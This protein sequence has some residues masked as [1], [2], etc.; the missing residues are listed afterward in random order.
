MV[1]TVC[2]HRVMV[3]TYWGPTQASTVFNF[4]SFQGGGSELVPED[5]NNT[6]KQYQC[7]IAR[8]C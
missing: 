8:A 5:F 6:L 2:P 7:V 4:T 3:P 1:L